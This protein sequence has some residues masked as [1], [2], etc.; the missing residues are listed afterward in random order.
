VITERKEL[1][2]DSMRS[3]LKVLPA[4]TEVGELMKR[5][6]GPARRATVHS[7]R[8]FCRSTTGPNI[9]TDGLK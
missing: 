8:L 5:A 4:I 7:H 1:T 2:P 9:P 6:D 3:V